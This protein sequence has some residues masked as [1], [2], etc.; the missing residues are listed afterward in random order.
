MDATT[1]SR[2]RAHNAYD[3]RRRLSFLPSYSG[4]ITPFAIHYPVHRSM[5]SV[6]SHIEGRCKFFFY[7]GL[8]D[9]LQYGLRATSFAFPFR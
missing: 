4:L 3:T 1:S 6:V 8:I 7:H 5:L 2:Q 9:R